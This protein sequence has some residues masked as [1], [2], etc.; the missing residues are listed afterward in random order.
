MREKKENE[1]GGI[2]K[3]VLRGDGSKNGR[4]ER[5]VHRDLFT[6]RDEDCK[7]FAMEAW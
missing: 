7:Q 4:K 3:K 5:T 2:K 6:W 1:N